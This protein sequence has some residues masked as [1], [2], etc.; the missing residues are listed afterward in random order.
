MISLLI[1][2]EFGRPSIYYLKSPFDHLMFDANLLSVG[3]VLATNKGLNTFSVR[4]VT[5]K[6]Q[7]QPPLLDHKCVISVLRNGTWM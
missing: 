6:L 4:L 3:L 1:Y 7:E 5:L 2:L